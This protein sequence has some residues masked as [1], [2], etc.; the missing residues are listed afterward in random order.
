MGVRTHYMFKE[1]TTS[2]VNIAAWY[3]LLT[4]HKAYASVGRLPKP[5]VPWGQRPGGWRSKIT[6]VYSELSRVYDSGTL[7]VLKTRN[8]RKNAGFQRYR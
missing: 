3:R 4:L 5:I 2:L 8:L 7:S 6:K 1:G